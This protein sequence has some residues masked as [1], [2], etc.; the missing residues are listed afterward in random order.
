[1]FGEAE[2]M[3]ILEELYTFKDLYT[4]FHAYCPKDTTLGIN[5]MYYHYPWKLCGT[6]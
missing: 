3:Y 1:M 2:F 6:N 5:K 4:K